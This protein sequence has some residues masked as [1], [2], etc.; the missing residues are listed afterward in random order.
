MKKILLTILSAAVLP[1]LSLAQDNNNYQCSNGDLQRRV[2]IVYETG[3]TVPC[4]VHYYKDTEA[5][6]ERQVLWRALNQEGYCEEQTRQFITQLASWGWD[7][8]QSAAADEAP[9]ADMPDESDEA[10]DTDALAP[11]DEVEATA[12]S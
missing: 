4:E 1:G 7:C 12:E 5:P 11:V 2:E 9:E 6:G 8:T 3:V 10:D